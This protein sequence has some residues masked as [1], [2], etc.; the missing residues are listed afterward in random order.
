MTEPTNTVR[1]VAAPFAFDAATL[2]IRRIGNSLGVVLPKAV[3]ERLGAG[4]GDELRLS[5]APGAVTLSKSD[6][7]VDEQIAAGR[8]VMERYAAALREL[9]K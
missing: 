8:K 6:A 4:E 7:L 9:A 3:L 5:E 2:K 1:E